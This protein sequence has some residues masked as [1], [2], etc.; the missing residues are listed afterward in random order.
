MEMDKDKNVRSE[1]LLQE[2]MKVQL[3]QVTQ[4]RNSA[5]QRH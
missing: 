4:G 3:T 5:E 1:G 2:R